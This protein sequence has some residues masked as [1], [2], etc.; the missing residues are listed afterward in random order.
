[1]IRPLGS[2][3]VTGPSSLLRVDPS[4]CPASVLAPLRLP[5]LGSSLG[6][7]TTGSKVPCTGL[8]HARA[9][10]RPDA[11]T[12]G[13]QNPPPLFPELTPCSGFDI[14]WGAFRPFIGRFT[15][16]RLRG[17]HLTRYARAFSRNVHHAR[18]LTAAACADL[19]P[20]SAARLRETCSHL[21]HS[22]PFTRGRR[23]LKKLIFRESDDDEQG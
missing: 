8:F 2:R 1:M 6:N 16:V 12:A 22:F 19:Q 20:G 5:R 10:S 4:L 7:G 21:V 15:C 23:N 17:T 14:V 9:A 11:A 13:L 18:L 3:P